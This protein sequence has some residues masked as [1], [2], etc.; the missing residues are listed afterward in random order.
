[1]TTTIEPISL[2]ARLR[3]RLS[4]AM[5][6]RAGVRHPGLS[7]R[8]RECLTSSCVNVGLIRD[9]VIEGALPYVTGDKNLGELAGNLLHPET[10]RALSHD[11]LNGFPLERKPYTHQIDAWRTLTS[12]NDPRSVVVSS[13]TGSGKTECFLVPMIDDF[14]RQVEGDTMEPGVQAIMLYPLNAL[15]ESQRERLD[16]WTAPLGGKV[17]YGLYNGDMQEN[18]PAKQRRADRANAPQE[19]KD[20]QSLREAPPSILVT[21][22]TMLEYMLV[23]PQ[24]KSILDASKGK[25]KWIILDEAH[26][27]VGAAAAEVALLLRRVM[28][29]FGVQAK[30]VRFVATSATIGEGAAARNALKQFMAQVSGVSPADVDVIEGTRRIPALPPVNKSG[31]LEALDS[32]NDADLYKA[33]G[34]NPIL[35]PVL[36]K[37]FHEPV[38]FGELSKAASEINVQVQDL[39]GALGRA[40]QGDDYLAPMRVHLFQRAL[41]GIWSCI[42]PKCSEVGADRAAGWTH[43]KLYFSHREK[44]DCGIAVLDILTCSTCGNSALSGE[45]NGTQLGPIPVR[46]VTD[47]LA[48]E[49]LRHSEFDDQSEEDVSDETSQNESTKCTFNVSGQASITGIPCYLDSK[50]TLLDTPDNSAVKLEQISVE[51]GECPFCGARASSGDKLFPFRFGTPFSMTNALPI[52]LE[53]MPPKS[54][55]VREF[56]YQ[57]PDLPADGRQLLSFTDSRQGTARMS[58]KI[59]KDAERIFTRSFVYQA[60]QESLASDND[61]D[62]IKQAEQSLKKLEV[63]G[64]LTDP[65]FSDIVAGLRKTI[66]GSEDGFLWADLE[67]RLADRIEVREWIAESW[68]NRSERFSDHGAARHIAKTL[69]MTELFRRPKTADSIETMGIARLY[70]PHIEK[71]V[72][73]KYSDGISVSDSDWRTYL[74]FIVTHTLRANVAVSLERELKNW[75]GRKL[76]QSTILPPNRETHKPSDLAWPQV[77]FGGSQSRAVKMLALGLELDVKQPHDKIIINRLLLAAYNQLKPLFPPGEYFNQLILEKLNIAPVKQAYYCPVTHTVHDIAP[78]GLTPYARSVQDK[79][80]PF[81]MPT[82]PAL[83]NVATRTDWLKSSEIGALR[84]QGIW[85]ATHDRLALFSPYFRTAEH[86][87]QNPRARLKLYEDRFKEN[88]INVLNCSTT[89]EMGVDIGSVSGVIMSNLP[90]AISNYRQRIGRAGRRRQ[91]VSIGYTIAKDRPL[92]LEA[93]RDP[94]LY[95]KRETQAPKIKLDS[96]PI[97][98]R[99]VNAELLGQFIREYDGDGF[100]MKIGPFMGCPEDPKTNRTLD[101]K[102]ERQVELFKKWLEAQQDDPDILNNIDRIVKG[103]NCA[104]RTDLV[105]QCTIIIS[106]IANS[107]QTEWRALIEQYGSVFDEGGAS[108]QK[109]ISIQIKRMCGEYLLSE[110]ADAGFLPSHGFP[111]HVVQFQIARQDK[112]LNAENNDR[113]KSF[114]GMPSRSLDVAIREFAPGAELMV[115]GIVYRSG[116]VTLNWR[117]PAALEGVTEIQSLKKMATCKSCAHIETNVRNLDSACSSCGSPFEVIHEYLRPSGFC[118]DR[119]VPVHGDVESVNFIPS[120][121]VAFSAKD[122]PW[123]KLPDPRLGNMRSGADGI[124]FFHTRGPAGLGYGL[125]L[126]CGRMEAM[127]L[128]EEICSGLSDHKPLRA[129]ENWADP[130]PGNKDG[131]KLRHNIFLGHNIRTDVFELHPNAPMKIEVAH[132][133]A[134]ALREALARRLG[135]ESAEIGYGV[136]TAENLLGTGNT[137]IGLYDKPSG[138]AGYAT[139][140][141]ENFGELVNIARAL[142]D[143]P[144]NCDN[145]C[146]ACILT[147]DAPPGGVH[148][149]DRHAAI[150]FMDDELVFNETLCLED[151]VYPDTR[152]SNNLIKDVGRVLRPGGMVRLFINL[153]DPAGL[154]GWSLSRQ[155]ERWAKQ[156]KRVTLVVEQ[157]VITGWTGAQS[158][159]VRDWLSKT[160]AKLSTGSAPTM[161]GNMVVVAQVENVDGDVLQ[162]SSRDP[163]IREPSNDWPITLSERIFFGSA[164]AIKTQPYD[165]L[166]LQGRAGASKIVLGHEFAGPLNAFG[167]KMA[168]RVTGALASLGIEVSD[169]TAAK[170]TDA[171]LVSPLTIRLLVDF[172]SR[173]LPSESTLEI[174]TADPER[175]NTQHSRG[176]VHG[177]FK[178]RREMQV[179]AREYG[180]GLGLNV[181]LRTE[182]VPHYRRLILTTKD[183]RSVN[184]DFD[185][186]MGWLSYHH[187][188]DW[189]IAAGQDYVKAVK[190]LSGT[191]KLNRGNESHAFLYLDDQI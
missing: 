157:E 168:K 7:K 35:Q 45:E 90:P 159:L 18:S 27:Y 72:A 52:L 1:M 110:L 111:N 154:P 28:N 107:F 13:G 179:F 69:L 66:S 130:C 23:R 83:S 131:Y 151:K 42:D 144:E 64:M 118:Q 46:G 123:G 3:E 73:P 126:H 182:L 49:A 164:D 53:S 143:C 183:G 161:H 85:I 169:L 153:S 102:D 51:T 170:Y 177:N 174:S 109:A 48:E 128:D 55:V 22:I 30:D 41:G 60:V 112:Y 10:V 12:L 2:V 92:D 96:D 94:S 158:L 103:S 166:K 127:K 120:E 39:M 84:E 140:A 89:M 68:A 108:A 4:E 163:L 141:E 134:I 11:P 65:T 6:S 77:K 167:P 104:G 67:A 5:I 80:Q 184:V 149:L 173:L 95:L 117:K 93:F 79:A 50:G 99:H 78:F 150:D 31:R 148:S 57:V 132:S 38:S 25:L 54:K 62:A 17:R 152:V 137:I 188:K 26:T 125:C 76:F 36:K 156:N 129:A 71:Q 86:S 185:Q 47:E 74:Y 75:F 19:V 171:Y 178:D 15:I 187:Q 165:R 191:V 20:R 56:P 122:A 32:Y 21:N 29:A 133:I 58:A 9:P 172:V 162:W 145:A 181:S 147:H 114:G 121:A 37:L 186:G 40:K 24:D 155:I 146:S 124:V 138:G 82:L 16:A 91:A 97:V 88:R 43:G 175:L 105:A 44:C 139:D 189:R 33:L 70:S 8:L 119:H 14:V 98:Q 113:P 100:K 87:A 34:S 136:K 115:D 81:Q 116:G 135:V 61:P 176:A 160:L 190:A 101:R 142:L 59:Q 63:A 106:K 180:E